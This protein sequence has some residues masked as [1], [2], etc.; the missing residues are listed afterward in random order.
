MSS[1]EVGLVGPGAAA[2][3]ECKG[4]LSPTR[5][6]STR[7]DRFGGAAN[8]RSRRMVAAAVIVSVAAAV[9]GAPNIVPDPPSI[10]AKS[11]ILMDGQ[12]R[13]IL[14]ERDS[15]Q[16]LPPASL[17]KIMT[18]FVAAAELSAGRIALDDQVPISVKAWRTSGSKMFV[19][20]G[21]E[22]ALG[23]LLRGIVVVS[24]NDASVAVAEYI[25]G[26]ED[27][28]A[29]MMNL[30]AKDLGMT[31]T[32]F[33]NSSGLPDDGHYS[34]AKD[35]AILSAALIERFP[36]HYRMYSERSFQFG[37]IERPQLNRNRLLWRDK[38]VDGVKTGMTE[39]AGF[40]L[41]ASALR[42]GTRLIAAVMGADNDEDRLR[43]TQKLLAY[44]FRY[45][46][47]HDLYSAGE[48]LATPRVWYGTVDEVAVGIDE[49]IRITVPRGRY[50][51][52]NAVLDIPDDIEA[53]IAAGDS[54]GVVRVTLDDEILAE[55][56]LLAQT[57]VAEVGFFSRRGDD[58]ERFF[59]G[60]FGDSDDAD[61]SVADP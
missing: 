29:D 26:A 7:P 40:C 5:R 22:V 13:T 8:V 10:S 31:G 3:G 32:R 17:T 4:A 14:A 37:E 61:E 23:D 50:D 19:R 56:S 2:H 35:M 49:T 27:A 51:D 53:P 1:T 15:E 25:A 43:D 52:L 47:T 57:A 18:S 42:E 20:E 11:Y 55:R 48:P 28:F 30:H 54:L 36:D 9:Q 33:V 34:S 24:G 44:G 16:P 21:T 39:A 46:E 60:L 45:F 38:S 12:T 41:V 59:G 58:L 6:R